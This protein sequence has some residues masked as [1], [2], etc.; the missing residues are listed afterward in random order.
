MQLNVCCYHIKSTSNVLFS[1]YTY[2]STKIKFVLHFPKKKFKVLAQDN[3]EK[4]KMMFPSSKHQQQK[5]D[6]HTSIS[7]FRNTIS[8]N[9]QFML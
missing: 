5:N 2:V 7:L 3:N 1:R 4:K 8:N 6:F 9:L